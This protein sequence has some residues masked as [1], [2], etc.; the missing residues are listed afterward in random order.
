MLRGIVVGLVGLVA[1]ALPA[2]AAAEGGCPNEA[3]RQQQGYATRLPDCRAYELVTPVEKA[4]GSL[5]PPARGGQTAITAGYYQASTSGEGLA[6]TALTPFPGTQWGGVGPWLASRGAGGWSSVALS[7]PQSSTG[8][9]GVM[10]YSSDLSKLAMLDGGGIKYPQDDPPLVSGEP[11]NNQ[12]LFL[13]DSATGS[14]QLMNLTPQ[15]ASPEE[16]TF[17][18]ASRDF[19]HIVFGSEALLIPGAVFSP[20]GG[21]LYQWSD[22]TVSLVS[23]VPVSPATSCGGGSGSPC[24][25]SERS[26]YNGGANVAPLSVVSSD[27]SRIFFRLPPEGNGNAGIF[28]TGSLYVRENNTTTSLVG[29]G[30][31]MTATPSGSKV[32]FANDVIVNQA[33]VEGDL[34]EYNVESHQTSDLTPGD[35]VRGVL[36]V[37]EDGSYVYFIDESYRLSLWHEGTTTVIATLAP[38]DESDWNRDSTSSITDGRTARVTPDGMHLAFES[39]QSL[40]GF[41]NR[42]A[43]TSQ[44]DDEVYLY[45]AGTNRL[46]C[47]SCAPSGAR[48]TAPA[49]ILGSEP[50]GLQYLPHDLSDDG[51]RLFFET[52]D[53]LV[54][55]DTNGQ[56]DVYEYEGGVPYLISSGTSG[57]D[58]SFLDA[59]PNGNDVFFETQAQLAGQDRD[60][61]LDIYD[62][63]VGGGFPVEPTVECVGAGCQSAPSAPSVFGAPASSTLAGTGNL[64]APV[65]PVVKPAQKR[66]PVQCRKGYVKK[67][68]K[69]VKKPRKAKRA[70]ATA[71]G[72]K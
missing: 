23:Q 42:D 33:V 40:T 49:S 55:G 44:P 26:A 15:G 71:K 35:H 5:A 59:S 63:R 1:L 17:A 9:I 14:Y 25:A 27:G 21:E 8:D 19:S 24:V 60:Q 31:Y 65:A 48:P 54:A 41:D 66:K 16:T 39:S 45:D 57:V 56:Q 69:C 72:R 43:V 61:K 52:A 10:G 20:N 70:K 32:F 51:S 11:A 30:L 12:N 7:P 2:G 47:A 29:S 46:V 28:Y 38:G 58:S 36:G 62:A 18:G 13:R 22:G 6:Y 53:A 68:G 4:G 37:S 34:N 3:I 67:K 64:P 50:E